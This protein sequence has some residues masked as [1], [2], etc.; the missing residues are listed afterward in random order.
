M[1]VSLI[2]IEKQKIPEGKKTIDPL[3]DRE[4]EKF[5]HYTSDEI[6]K[7]VIRYKDSD[8]YVDDEHYNSNSIINYLD[9]LLK[10]TEKILNPEFLTKQDLV[11]HYSRAIRRIFIHTLKIYQKFFIV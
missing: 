2:D 3:E 1:I 4:L 11:Y 7:F 8:N 9:S 5:D 6:E 10:S